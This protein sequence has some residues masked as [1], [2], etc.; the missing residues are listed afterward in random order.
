MKTEAAIAGL[1]S[2]AGVAGI[3][4]AEPSW[5]NLAITVPRYG[6]YLTRTV[7]EEPFFWQADT[8]WKLV[9]R[10]NKT[11][12]GFYL[13][14]RAEQGYNVVQTVLVSEL[15]G[16]TRSNF[17]GD[18]PFSN[19]DP[20][21]PNDAYFELVDWTVDLAASYG[22]LMALVPT[23]GMYVNGGWHSTTP[24]FNE[25]NAYDWGKYI[26]ERYP[27]LPKLL[28]G[29]SNVMWSWNISEVQAA[30]A[31]DPDQDLPSLLAP[32]EDTSAV[33]ASMNRGLKEAERAQG[34]E[35]VVIYHPAAGW[36]VKPEVTPEAYGHNVLPNEQDRMSIDAVQSGHATP[37]PT[38]KFTPTIG[39][40]STKNY[41]LI[42]NMR[43]RSTG[44]VIDLENHYE[45][46]HDSF[47]LE[48][49]IWNSSQIRTGLYHG[50]YGGACGFTYGAN[51]VW[52]MYEP[53]S[54]LLR[55]ND[56]PSSHTGKSVNTYE[57]TR[58]ISVLATKNRDRYYVYTGHG[59]SFALQLD[60]GSG[61]RFGTARW[62]SPRDGQYY[63]DAAISVLERGNATHIDFTPPSGG[64]IDDDWLLVLEF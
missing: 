22:I 36:I 31:E 6:R 32:I 35:S 52:Q 34:Y 43:D 59:D 60:N 17:Y 64:S 41:D 2:L 19:S 38:S 40:D 3:T 57:G 13:K 58:Y 25:S 37:D 53:R 26:G 10:L 44:P 55:D 7:S 16:T 33:W 49:Q 61:A 30:Y 63:A 29:D 54:A 14:T 4:S 42:A 50:V 56:C 23:W 21:Q 48:R 47:N 45:G 62:F 51:S 1:L 24:I 12:I 8:A 5:H 9:H 11:S 39:W 46:A 15:N 20:T 27:G 18:L 28:G